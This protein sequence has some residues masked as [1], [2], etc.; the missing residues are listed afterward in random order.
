MDMIGQVNPPTSKGY[1]RIL[2]ATD[3]FTKWVEAVSMK[4]VTAKDVVIFLKEHIIYRFGIPQTITTDQGTVFLAEEFKNFAKEMGIT[5]LQS[6]SYYAQASGQAE[7][8]NKS[9]IKLIKRKIDEYPKQWHD[10]L[11]EAL[12]AY[13]M[14]CHGATKC[15]PYQLVYGQEA[16]MPWEVN[17][18]SRRIQFQNNLSA[19]DYASLMNINTDYLTELRLWAFEK[20]RDN[21]GRVAKAYNKKVKP[22]NFKV[23]D[24]IWGLASWDERS[25][26]W[27]VV[28]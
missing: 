23:G 14:S 15:T 6:S 13:R 20:I 28:T 12:W 18:V 16:V 17:I 1:K 11:A 9:L 24:L 21:K 27:K 4:N 19:D 3:Y 10:R 5:L 26:I 22:K 2:V 25:S 7:A 8:S